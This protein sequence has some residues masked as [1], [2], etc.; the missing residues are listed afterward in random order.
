MARDTKAD[1]AVVEAW[2]AARHL[3]RPLKNSD[4]STADSVRP[5]LINDP[6]WTTFSPILLVDQSVGSSKLG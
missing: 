6:Y 5:D 1:P 4:W 2:K 3:S